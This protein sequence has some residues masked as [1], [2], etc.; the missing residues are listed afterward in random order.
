MIRKTLAIAAIVIALI[1]II[2]SS[3]PRVFAWAFLKPLGRITKHSLRVEVFSYPETGSS[4]PTSYAIS[5]D[6]IQ[7]A[8]FYHDRVS[9]YRFLDSRNGAIVGS[10]TVPPTP[11]S[12]TTP[13]ATLVPNPA[14]AYCDHGKYLYGPAYAGAVSFFDA[15][16]L[17]LLQTISL[18]ELLLENKQFPFAPKGMDW[19]EGVV[20]QCANDSPLSVFIFVAAESYQLRVFDLDKMEVVA[21]TTIQQNPLLWVPISDQLSFPNATSFSNDGSLAALQL[22]STSDWPPDSRFLIVDVISG[23]VLRSMDFKQ[24]ARYSYGVIFAG[25]DA[26]VIGELNRCEI[27][28][29]VCNE[30][31]AHRALKVWNFGTD[32]S[33]ISLGNTGMETYGSFGVSANG[34]RIYSYAGLERWCYHCDWW[35]GNLRIEDARFVVWDR[36]SDKIIYRSQ[37]IPTYQYKCPLIPFTIMGGK[38]YTSPLAPEFQM[39][40]DGNALMEF[41]PLLSQDAAP[42]GFKDEVEIFDLQ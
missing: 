28:D 19:G 31:P 30:R 10:F 36:K 11:N 8:L 40:G 27:Y 23:R 41:W 25:N 14:L 32:A 5:P 12:L 21:S 13:R 3:W 4:L 37:L 38:C 6:G 2:Q 29:D 18:D 35:S 33:F 22:Q 20:F 17:N 39:S 42:Q 9:H 16:S 26:L 7:V 15:H 34:S 1:L 24:G